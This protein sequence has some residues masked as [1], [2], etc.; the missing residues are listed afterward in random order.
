M[1]SRQIKSTFS[2]DLLAPQSTEVP[3]VEDLLCGNFGNE[4]N[5][6]S[7]NETKFS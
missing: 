4:G 5:P 2:N 7:R 1:E 3:A 6:H